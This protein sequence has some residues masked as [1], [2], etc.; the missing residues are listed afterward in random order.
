[1]LAGS[2]E[3]VKIVAKRHDIPILLLGTTSPP[4]NVEEITLIPPMNPVALF[5]AVVS[6]F[7]AALVAPSLQRLLGRATAWLLALVPLGLTAYFG[8]HIESVAAGEHVFLTYSWVP[9]LGIS[10]SLSLDGLSLLFALLISGIGTL[11]VIYA[12]GYL[13]EH[14]RLGRFHAFLLMFMASMLGLVLANNLLTLFVFWELTSL[15]SYFL[16]GFENEREAARKAAWQALLVTAGGGLTLLAGFVLLGQIAGSYEILGPVGAGPEANTL[17]GKAWYIQQHALYLPVLVLILIGAFTKSAQ[18]PFHFWLPSAMEAPTPVSAY[19]H[20]ATMVKAGIYLLA[21]LFPV[22]GGREE[23]FLLVTGFGIA[24]MLIGGVLAL[25]TTDLKRILAYS[26]VSALGML[27]AMLGCGTQ[28]AM[29]A[30]IVYL[31]AHALYKGALFLMAGALDHETGTREVTRLSGLGKVMPVTAVAG[32]LAA[33]SMAGIPPL[34]GFI[35][36]EIYYES[37]LAAP[38]AY[39]L[40]GTGVVASMMFVAVAVAVGIRPFVGKAGETPKKPHEAPL[41]LWL[42]IVLLAGL[43]LL[44]GLLPELVEN[45]LLLP[46]VAAAFPGEVPPFHLE[47]WHGWTPTVYL[48]LLTLAGGLGLYTALGAIR[49]LA[50]RWEWLFSFGPARGYEW[51]LSGVMKL[52]EFQTR[53]LQS[54]YLRSYLITILVFVAGLT[55]FSLWFLGWPEALPDVTD[56][57]FYE[58][59][60]S[61]LV[62]VGALAV[63]LSR[64]RF[65]AVAALGVV[66]YGVALIFMLF[67]A[68][69]LAM[70]Q[71]LIE[72]LTVI[73]FVLVFY[74]LPG[75]RDISSRPIYFRDALISIV[76]GLLMTGLVLATARWEHAPLVS[77]YY[78]EHSQ[79]DGHGRNIVNVILV[80]FRALDTLGEISV[81]AL[82]GVGVYALLKLRLDKRK[83]P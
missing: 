68:P 25:Q 72:S 78:V 5:V 7:A 61:V 59:G 45:R 83:E 37:Q 9:S 44:F 13:A 33:L 52:A 11:V 46:A 32:V 82:A 80:D 21:R 62:V 67:S 15:T 38:A 81:L 57:R 20:S 36:K 71:F 63:V 10:V 70:T 74:H 19:L 49:S 14:P 48:S 79:P 47:L 28:L 50:A 66:G 29:Q 26:T 77:Q 41:A 34:F 22:L 39:L 43:G 76:A 4:R 75:F 64:S 6:G 3:P 65:A 24:T 31:F 16:I 55:G 27:T 17:T 53:L 51:L 40:I 23:W 30:A 73:L 42:G 35:A 12:G 54:G 2:A 8:S 69:D 58:I 1:M 56:A 18:F 60:L